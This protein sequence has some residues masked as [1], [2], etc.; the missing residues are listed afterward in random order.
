MQTINS[1]EVP[2]FM[3]TIYVAYNTPW[4]CVLLRTFS[5]V[6]SSQS[7]RSKVKINECSGKQFCIAYITVD[8]VTTAMWQG[9]E[10]I[11]YAMY[12]VQP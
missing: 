5:S 12:C 9:V 1:L 8:T 6:R 11:I 7:N 10:Y 4:P 2:P 3:A